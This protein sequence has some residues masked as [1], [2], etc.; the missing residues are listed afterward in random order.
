MSDVYPP[1]GSTVED[2]DDNDD[3]LSRPV[4]CFSAWF[5]RTHDKWAYR[6]ERVVARSACIGDKIMLLVLMKE[7]LVW[8]HGKYLVSGSAGP[9]DSEKGDALF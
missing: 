2:D 6:L 4:W 7:Y 3:E 8:T 5:R 9:P 1:R